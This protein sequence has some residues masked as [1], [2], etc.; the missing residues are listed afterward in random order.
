MEAH[1]NLIDGVA[2]LVFWGVLRDTEVA[3]VVRGTCRNKFDGLHG[4]RL[5]HVVTRLA[6]FMGNEG[7]PP[8]AGNKRRLGFEITQGALSEITPLVLFDA[9]SMF[10]NA[11]RFVRESRRGEGTNEGICVG[12]GLRGETYGGKPMQGDLKE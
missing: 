6:R 8:P 1:T 10:K 9:G 12:G 11:L 7:A 4:T 5:V 3:N 2:I